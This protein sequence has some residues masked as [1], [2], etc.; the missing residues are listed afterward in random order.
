M[1]LVGLANEIGISVSLLSRIE[2]GNRRIKSEIIK[3]IS[4]KLSIPEK[5][6]EIIT[7][8]NEIMN[9]YGSRRYFKESI[10][11]IYEQKN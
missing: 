8:S 7:I 4:E 10:K 11:N 1:S 2:N 3:R 9:K 6:L 5:E